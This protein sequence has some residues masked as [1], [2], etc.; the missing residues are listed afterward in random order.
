MFR[1]GGHRTRLP[2]TQPPLHPRRQRP[3]FL[4]LLPAPARYAWPAAA[5]DLHAPWPSARR[6][7][8]APEARWEPTNGPQRTQWIT[9][10]VALLMAST[11]AALYVTAAPTHKATPASR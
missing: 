9:N 2:A 8:S 3:V 1:L 10:S 7:E 11:V 6:A 4:D 5:G